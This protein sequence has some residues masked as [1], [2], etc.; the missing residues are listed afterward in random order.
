MALPYIESISAAI[1]KEMMLDQ[2]ASAVR[3]EKSQLH[4]FVSQSQIAL[5]KTASK[6]QRTPMRL[7]IALLLQNPELITKIGINIEL[8]TLSGSEL[9]KDIVILLQ[10]NS[11]WTTGN[12][13]EYFREKSESELVHRLSAWNHGVPEEGISAEFLDILQHLQ[14]LQRQKNIEKLLQK[15]NQNSLT[16]PER[17]QLQALL[18][19]K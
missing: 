19:E 6:I 13:L 3:L 10:E 14:K 16:E 5:P 18:S 7:A 9:F 17:V 12:I 15:A 2:L 4:Q 11:G 1:F 8:L